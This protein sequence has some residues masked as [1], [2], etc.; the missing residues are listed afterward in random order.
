MQPSILEPK[1][2][3][4]AGTPSFA[5]PSLIA[6]LKAKYSIIGVYTQPDRPAGRGQKLSMSPIKEAALQYGLP[7]F[8]PETLSSE[9][10]IRTL[11]A[12][13][14]DMLVV[15]AYGLI[16]PKSILDIPSFGCLNIHASLLPRWRGAAPIERAIAAGDTVTG[17]TLMHMDMGLD[18]GDILTQ[19]TCPILAT[20]TSETLRS[21]LANLGAETLIQTLSTFKTLFAQKK[22]QD[23]T[24]ATY[25]RKLTKAEAHLDWQQSADILERKI[26]AY[27]PW[28]I[29]YTFLDDMPIRIHKAMVRE[30][31]GNSAKPGTIVSI[32]KQSVAVAAGTG[33]VQLLELQLPGKKVMPASLVVNGHANLFRIGR[34]FR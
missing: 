31:A 23:T 8:E 17:V 28:P 10:T 25:A 29:A 19:T 13:H 5:V 14:P 33:V 30:Q 11:A 9:E 27:N 4:F 32:G 1:K 16:L 6:L 2:L 3:I 15:V 21:R 18:T 22:P 24:K 12:L 26:R 20:D 34:V 7:I